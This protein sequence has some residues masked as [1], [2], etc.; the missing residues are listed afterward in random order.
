MEDQ[1]FN[2]ACVQACP[3]DAMTFGDLNNP[4][5]RVSQKWEDER[6]FRVL[7]AL[8]TNPSVKYLKQVDAHA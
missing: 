1:A 6:A 2:P 8:G 7:E 3:T 4:D 5:S